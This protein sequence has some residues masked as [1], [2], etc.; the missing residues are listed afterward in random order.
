MN[1]VIELIN[2]KSNN[3]QVEIS[4]KVIVGN[5][6]VVGPNCKKFSIGY[7]S[8]IGNDCYIDVPEFKIGDYTTIH[9]HGTI[10]G[11]KNVSIGHNCW[12]GQFCV[13]DSIGGTTIGNN[14]G[15][16]AHSQLWSHIKFGDSLEGCRWNDQK[17]LLVEDD[18]WFVGH[19]IV[20]PI[21]AQKKSMLLAGGVITKD[22]EENHVYGGSPA[23]DITDKVGNQFKE[24][25]IETKREEF[26]SLHLSFLDLKGINKEK[27]QATCVE[28]LEGK[29]S[30]ENET[31][32]D[33]GKRLYLPARSKYEYEFIK[34]MLYEKAKFCPFEK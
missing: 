22:M 29:V 1:N 14:V 15:V 18:V 34:F 11:Y 33:I 4:N 7:G 23:K 31:Y 12:I 16:G 5:N 30:T 20:S 17:K 24:K 6:V 10:H 19:C 27:F 28:D 26:L 32:F 3:T 25:S 9:N 2:F 21:L 13:I 8:F